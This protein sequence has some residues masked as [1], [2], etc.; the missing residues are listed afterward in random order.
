LIFNFPPPTRGR[1][2]GGLA[3]GE[4]PPHPPL[5]GEGTNL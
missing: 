4:T 5:V 2:G 1:R 3:N